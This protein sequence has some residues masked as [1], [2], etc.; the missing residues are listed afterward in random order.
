MTSTHHP[1]HNN[2]RIIIMDALRGIAILGI[3]IANLGAGFSFYNESAPNSG[4]F[5][6]SLDRPFLFLEQMLIEGK[7]YSIFSFLFGWGFAIQIARSEVKGISPASFMKRR[8]TF[9]F[10]LGLAH[11]L[12]LW[13]GDI[14]AFYA[15]V[16][17]VL[18]WIRNWK[19]K[20]LFITAIICLL[21]PAVLYF[22][23]MKFP[24]LLAVAGIFFKTG[25]A[26]EKSISGVSGFEEFAHKL[27]TGNYLFQ[28][29]TLLSG[30][31]YRYGDL[32]FQDRFFKVLG[33]FIIGYLLGRDGRYK[34]IL[35]NKPLLLKVA[36]IGL[37]IGLPANYVMAT[38]IGK[39]GYYQMNMDG[40]IQ[41]LAYTAGVSTLALAYI[42]LFFLLA[43]TKPGMQVIKFLQPPGKMAV[44]NYIMHSLI[45]SIVFYGMGFG[46]MGEVGPFYYTI[47][48][49]IVFAAQ[50]V[51]STIWLRYFNYGPVEWLWRSATYKKWQPLR[52]NK[53]HT[54]A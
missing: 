42:A 2:E 30:V 47:L 37:A 31:F 26:I 19:D 11:L 22:L 15:L 9:M 16:G 43:L 4:P 53:N 38:Y 50:I 20:K 52:K 23:K 5:F 12:L 13:S 39:Y 10:L 34:T 36:V 1:V 14:V 21:L 35:I 6:H 17:F 24:S 28:L 3:F 41:T 40:I 51:L 33:M 8:L 48:A 54:A 18:L 44:S 7:F 46:M 32:I 27:K 49:W 29:K 25:E 45:G